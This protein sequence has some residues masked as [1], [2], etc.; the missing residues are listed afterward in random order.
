MDGVLKGGD[1][2]GQGPDGLAV[3]SPTIELAVWNSSLG[4]ILRKDFQSRKTQAR[5]NA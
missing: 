2:G 4:K 5:E 3:N 1:G